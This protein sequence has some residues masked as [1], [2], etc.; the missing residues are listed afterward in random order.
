MLIQPLTKPADFNALLA[1]I[2]TARLVL[3]G[4]ATHGTHDYY[5]LREQLTRRL[6]AERGF[7]FVAVEG[8][9]PD[10]DRVHRS[11]TGAPDAPDPTTALHE[12]QR[13]PTWMWANAEVARSAAGCGPGTSTSQP[14]PGPASTGWTSTASGSRCRRSSTTSARRTRLAGGGPGR[15][16]LLRAV[17][18]AS[19]RSTRWPA[20]SSRPAAR[21]RWSG[22]W[23][24]P[25]RRPPPDGAGPL[26]GLAERGGGGR[27]RALLPGD[28][29]RRPGVVERPRHP[30]GRH[31]GP[32]AGRTT[33]RDA[34]AI[35][36]AHNTHVGDARATDM[37][38]DGMV[39]IG[40]LARERH[41]GGRGGAGRLR[42]LPRAR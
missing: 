30:H 3:L 24:V 42:Q 21:R 12:F 17:R 32:A 16:P 2:G 31:P 27:R 20:G 25:G 4:E 1:R 41:G 36:W 34:R 14:G 29:R 23:R 6:I 26:R 9:W 18:R 28:G 10:C 11:V 33:A 37:A 19:R 15:V 13:W 38:G 39:N 40:Q 7:S 8:D 35:V 22:C 5:R